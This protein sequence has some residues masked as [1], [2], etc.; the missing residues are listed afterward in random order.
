MCQAPLR[1][2]PRVGQGRK[3][4]DAE[5]RGEPAQPVNVMR[6]VR[7]SVVLDERSLGVLKLALVSIDHRDDQGEPSVSRDPLVPLPRRQHRTP[8]VESLEPR[9][10]EIFD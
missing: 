6:V 7:R 4:G 1:L 3:A 8:G 2:L 10:P 5:L 9:N